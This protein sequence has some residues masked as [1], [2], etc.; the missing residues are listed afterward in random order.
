MSEY[1]LINMPRS[2]MKYEF[3]DY[4]RFRFGVKYEVYENCDSYK[5]LAI[6]NRTNEVLDEKIFIC[7]L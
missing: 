7:I 6:K 1:R 5:V 2:R 4:V 3:G